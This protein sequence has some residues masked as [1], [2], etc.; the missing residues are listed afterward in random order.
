MDI[1]QTEVIERIARVLAGRR[2]SINGA[3][4]NASAAHQVDGAW[5]DF[6]D[7]AIAVLRTLREPDAVMARAGDPA[8]W[9]KMVLAALGECAETRAPLHGA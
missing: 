1:S 7:D 3:G 9:E 2:F 5:R 8:I 4:S 6:R